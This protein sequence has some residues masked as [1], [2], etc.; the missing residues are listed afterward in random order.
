MFRLSLV[1]VLTFAAAAPAQVPSSPPI[2]ERMGQF[3]AS[4]DI[5]GAVTVVG[6]AS[7][8]V[9]LDAVGY[10]DLE[11]KDPMK[12]DALFRVA[13]MTKP[14]TAIGVMILA[15]RGKLSVEDPV[16]K[17]LPEFKGQMLVAARDKDTLTLKKP[18]RPITLRD[19]LTHT[20]GLPSGY[21]PG[22]ADVYPRRHVTL[23]E[24]IFAQSQRP[25]DFAPGEKWSYC[26][27]GLDTLG[28]VI[29]VVSGES[30]GVFLQKNVFDPLGMTDTTFYPT[31]VQLARAAVLYDK[32]D[33]KLVPVAFPFLGVAAPGRH[34]VPAGGMWSTGADL[35]KFYR[36]MLHKGELNGH[37]ILSEKAVAEMTKVQT[38]DLKCGFVDGMSFGYG[39]AVVREPQ[40]ITGMLSAGTFGHGGAFGTQGWIDPHKDLFVVLLIQ[41]NGL[42]NSD[43]SPMRRA[44]QEEAVK[45]VGM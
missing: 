13:S 20:S 6:R 45:L 8:I 33:G 43:A 7:G 30:Y 29:E 9:A 31:P 4:E 21:P 17:H 40:G 27:A 18:P 1:A 39:F 24:A 16:E 3:V 23:A 12:P 42:P 44:L 38:G 36:M 25:L 28:R 37:R 11:A 14:V 15:D 32:K 10:R 5:S 2:A 41:R 35:A 22:L 34:P 19:L 26:N